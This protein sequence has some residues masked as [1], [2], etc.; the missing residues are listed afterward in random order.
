LKGFAVISRAVL[1]RSALHGLEQSWAPL[2]WVD[3]LVAEELADPL[4]I[5]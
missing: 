3:G 2:P 5:G 4:A 1:V